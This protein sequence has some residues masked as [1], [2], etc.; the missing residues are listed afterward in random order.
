MY[1]ISM[2]HLRGQLLSYFL[3]KNKNTNNNMPK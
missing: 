2:G 3:C 1:G